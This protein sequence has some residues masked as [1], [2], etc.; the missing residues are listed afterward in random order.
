M[1]DL[2]ETFLKNTAYDIKEMP[3]AYFNDTIN[4]KGQR[5]QF[6]KNTIRLNGDNIT[7]LSTYFFSDENIDLINKQLLLK[8]YKKS[9]KKYKIPFQSKTNMLIVMRYVWIQYSKNLDFNIKEQIKELNCIVV[10]E[11][12]PVV[13]TNIDQNIKYLEMVEINETSKFNVNT[14]PISSNLETA[15]SKTANLETPNLQISNDL[16]P[17]SSLFKN[18]NKSESNYDFIY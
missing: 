1:A 4:N 14:L 15:N 12:Y 8:V 9:N 5:E 3:V 6:I 13:L 2:N 11:I 10:G 16:K 18:E 17:I 7:E